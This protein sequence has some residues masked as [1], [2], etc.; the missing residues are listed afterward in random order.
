[1]GFME[2]QKNVQVSGTQENTTSNWCNL[3]HVF[4]FQYVNRV[5]LLVKCF[6]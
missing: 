2:I 5:L 4:A 3:V 6:V 1:M